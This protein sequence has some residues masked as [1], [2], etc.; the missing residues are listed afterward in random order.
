MTKENQP[1]KFTD[2]TRSAEFLIRQNSML[3][4]RNLELLHQQVSTQVEMKKSQQAFART[5]KKKNYQ[6]SALYIAKTDT[7]N[8]FTIQMSHS[9]QEAQA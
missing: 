7:S 9:A 4:I 1:H 6:P 8:F 2:L 5:L 3:K